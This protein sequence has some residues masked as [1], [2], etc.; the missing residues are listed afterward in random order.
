MAKLFKRPESINEVLQKETTETSVILIPSDLTE[1]KLLNS[2]GNGPELLFVKALETIYKLGDI[3]DFK[4]ISEEIA[5][6]VFI[7]IFDN[8]LLLIW[9]K[10]NN[11][12]SLI[13][14][15]NKLFLTYRLG[16]VQLNISEENKGDFELYL[17]DSLIVSLARK[18]N[19]EEEKVCSFYESFFQS[20]FS[21]I[22]E[23]N[24]EVQEKF[25]SVV[26]DENRC[27]FDIKMK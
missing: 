21:K 12:E 19:I 15:L 24:V 8:N 16:Y 25:C 13:N 11:L 26:N 7:E 6:N 23:E 1:T 22:F 2:I 14:Y 27:V 20:L 3:D 10:D 18:N 5:K 17:Y 4:Y 9:L